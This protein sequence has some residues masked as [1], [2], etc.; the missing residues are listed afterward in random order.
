MEGVTRVAFLVIDS[1][2]IQPYGKDE[3][4]DTE[5]HLR[6]RT[7]SHSSRRQPDEPGD[8]VHSKDDSVPPD[9]WVVLLG[10]LELG[11]DDGPIRL[12]VWC[13]HAEYE[14]EGNADSF[15]EYLYTV[16]TGRP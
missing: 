14:I 9:H 12:R 6:W 5:E 2:L 15:S 7:I 16:V 4:P 8:W 1:D 11:D 13:W 3:E 10:G